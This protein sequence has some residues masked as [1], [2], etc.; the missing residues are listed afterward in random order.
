MTTQFILYTTQDFSIPELNV[1]Y[2]YKSNQFFP[3]TDVSSPQINTNVT[4]FQLKTIDVVDTIHKKINESES[5]PI[6][7]GTENVWVSIG[8]GPF[9]IQD[10]TTGIKYIPQSF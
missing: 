6:T 9:T 5:L 2:S 1:R 3:I 8:R 10:D 7:E 4:D